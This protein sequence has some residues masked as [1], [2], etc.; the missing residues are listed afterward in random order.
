MLNFDDGDGRL[1]ERNGKLSDQSY[2]M[3]DEINSIAGPH[4]RPNNLLTK[5]T[6]MDNLLRGLLRTYNERADDDFASFITGQLF[7]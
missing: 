3:G 1:F 2:F 5:P 7:K 4:W 6:F